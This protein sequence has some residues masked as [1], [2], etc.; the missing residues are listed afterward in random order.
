MSLELKRIVLFVA[1]LEKQAAYYRDGLG[2]PVLEEREGWIEFD[3]GGCS[4]ALHRGARK[5]R[6]DFATAEPLDRMHGDLKSRGVKL[7]EIKKDFLDRGHYCRG[8][9]AEGNPFQIST[10]Y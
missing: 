7:Q 5:S 3:A 9:D 4:I 2:L 1:D 6:L 8:K 10:G